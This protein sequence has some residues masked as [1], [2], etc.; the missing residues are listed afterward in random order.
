MGTGFKFVC[1]KSAAA[2]MRNH[3]IYTEE[4]VNRLYL[5]PDGIDRRLKTS[6]KKKTVEVTNFEAG[7]EDN[8]YEE[9]LVNEKMLEEAKFEENKSDE[10][11]LEEAETK[12]LKLEQTTETTAQSLSDSWLRSIEEDEVT[13]M[14]ELA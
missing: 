11:M 5:Y 2:Y 12:V 10:K 4:D 9:K 13:F 8:E 1:F 6:N 7:Q 14:S 3:E